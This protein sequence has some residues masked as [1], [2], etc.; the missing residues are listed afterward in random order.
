NKPPCS[1]I[2]HSGGRAADGPDMSALRAGRQCRNRAP[3]HFVPGRS[4][5]ET[6]TTSNGPACAPR[7]VPRLPSRCSRP[8]L[9]RSGRGGRLASQ[10]SL[11][12]IHVTLRDWAGS[13]SSWFDEAVNH[14]LASGAFEV[15]FKLV[16]FLRGDG[17]I[18]ELVVEHPRADRDVAAGF[19]GEARGAPPRFGNA[20][21]RGIEG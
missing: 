14:P 4:A 16:A 11:E 3:F 15:D 13:V 5:G 19:G 9:S 20:A 17:A 21:R 1:S 8:A 2:R 7:P 12:V 6:R 10:I 18:A